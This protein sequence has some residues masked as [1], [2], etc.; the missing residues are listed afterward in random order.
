MNQRRI[1]MDQ[2]LELVRLH[3]MGTGCRKVAEL[4]SMSPNTERQYRTSI[5]KAGL[6][7]GPVDDLP[8]L[9]VLRAAVAAEQSTDSSPQ[10]TSLERW[11]PALEKL[12][13]AGVRPRAAY[14]RLRLEHKDFE[15]SYWA[16]KRLW[17]QYRKQRGVRAED[18]AIPV[19]TGPGEVAQ[20]DFGYVGR[21]YDPQTGTLRKTWAFVM[22]LGHS[23]HMV[24]RLVF[25]QRV[26]TWLALHVEA[27]AELG[28]VVQ[29]IVP[30]NLKA[31]VVRA[32]FGASGTTGLNRSYRE[33]ARHYGFKI[34]PTPPRS[35]QKKGKVESGVK[36]VK[37]N[38]MA[39]REE[40]DIDDVRRDLVRWV[41]EVAG[42]RIHGTTGEQPLA[43]F[44]TVERAAL[45]PLPRERF[46]PVVWAE[47]TVHRDSHIC[48]QKR[49]YSVPWRLIGKE[50]WVRATPATVAIYADD[51]R[52]ATHE[53]RGRGPKSTQD[54]HLPD[55]RA[56]L[57][58]RSREYWV[59]R[60]EDLHPDV[61]GFVREVF[62]ADDVLSML[63][64]VQAI[65]T[66][67]QKYPR[68]RAAAACR[69]A[70]FYGSYSYGAIKNIL[71]RGLDFEPLPA[72]VMAPAHPAQP[73]RFARSMA[74]LIH[75][76]VEDT[77]E[78]N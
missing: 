52:V 5:A 14:D 71:R 28:G 72:A 40:Q 58:H 16:V 47:A 70:S 8:E 67:L 41:R 31:A 76:N 32:A 53:R 64:Q 54:E 20:V 23:R 29:T 11:R 39:G 9:E 75:H 37:R 49:L 42:L 34:D 22:V 66:Y 38:F 59:G 10:P 62:D 68:E 36:Y 63:R 69:R 74:E 27:L 73:M 24:V 19:E 56:P 44:E 13:K 48:F 4:L 51:T 50:V 45:L 60:A 25:D 55:H 30:D 57:R 33:L 46:E 77:D 21:L 3:R 61:G 18:V 65:V 26:E 17:R 35:P 1:D 15:G 2:L 12:F 6:L 43:V 7:E 78:P